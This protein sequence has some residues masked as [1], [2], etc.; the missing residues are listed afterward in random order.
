M[1]GAAGMKHY[2]Q[3]L[4]LIIS[5]ITLFSC[6][7]MPAIRTTAEEP[8]ALSAVDAQGTG[9]GAYLNKYADSASPTQQV[10]I[11]AADYTDTDMQSLTVKQIQDE[12]QNFLY[13]ADEG[14][15]RWHFTVS[16]PGLYSMKVR[17]YTE[18]GKGSAA[19]RTVLIDGRQPYDECNGLVLKRTF[20]Q[21]TQKGAFKKD[22]Q[23]NDIRPAQHEVFGV[24]EQFLY[25]SLGF[26][27]EPLQIYLTAGEHTLDFVSVREP[28][29]LYSI[30]FCKKEDVSYAE[31]IAKTDYKETQD[32]KETVQCEMFYQTSDGTIYPIYD[33]T[34]PIT[35][36]QSASYTLLNTV[37]GG[38][39][40]S[41]GQWISWKITV[42]KDGLYAV[43]PRFR[44][45]TL[46]GMFVT[47][48][49]YIDSEIPFKEAESIQFDYNSSWQY[50]FIS[51]D[52]GK[53]YLF[54]LSAGEH[55]IKMEVV[56]GS[57]APILR[58]VQ[59]TLVSL[60]SC[61]RQILMITGTQ[62]D[63]YRDYNFKNLIPE[64]LSELSVQADRLESVADSIEEKVGGKGLQISLLRKIALQVRRMSAKP[65]TIGQ[66]FESFKTN[67]GSLGSWV[68]TNSCQPLELDYITVASPDKTLEKAD[69]NFFSKLIF[70][71][72]KFVTTFFIDSYS[73][74]TTASTDTGNAKAVKVWLAT[75]RDQASVLRT[76]IDDDFTPASGVPISLELTAAGTLLPAVLAGVGPDV[77]VSSDGPDPVNYALRDAVYDLSK[78]GDFDE[79][80]NR[81]FSSSLEGFTLNDSVYALP[82]TQ[83]FP[84]LFYRK[85]IFG[86]LELT[87]PVTWK[88]FYVVT[89]EIQK[90]NMQVGLASP[91][92]LY[93]ILMYQRGEEL[94]R[95]NGALVNVDSNESLNCFK[96]V[97]DF[98]TQYKLPLTFDFANRFRTGEMPMA[99]MD[100]TLYNQMVVFAPEI[101]GMWAFVPVPGVLRE[102]GTVNN[103]VPVSC[104]G[105]MLLKKAGDKEN[106]WEF[107]KWWTSEDVQA[108]Y[109]KEMENVLGPS[110]K[111]PTA[112]KNA[113]AKLPWI[114]GDYK[115]L[116]SQADNTK[117]VPVYPGS[118]MLE[119]SM[120]FAFT[121]VYNTG[122]NPIESINDYIDEMNDELTRKRKEFDLNR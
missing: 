17:Y 74:G 105:T 68:L 29:S 50:D 77:A 119:R 14:F 71:F 90:Q 27:S 2:K 102:D 3:G 31:Y 91:Y 57:L 82:E 78:F 81:F 110:A 86:Q 101:K 11:N 85:D 115:S 4:S 15:V 62:T 51:D 106:C 9:Y 112:N 24:K 63:V 22:S 96:E 79:V 39:W 83:Q 60:N 93:T 116:S 66:S 34:S 35:Q 7:F 103:T 38:K 44:Q 88:E 94:F 121:K 84:M 87:V 61:Y 76:M 30:T 23:N 100:Y 113:L 41:P 42:P 118:Y 8:A 107:M 16:E 80:K 13:T 20:E 55:E 69:S 47:R 109:G 26:Y 48:R 28:V 117:G 104:L 1:K 37:G 52:K 97:C 99:I 59:E 64:V 6:I 53:P 36:P 12:P 92:S 10:V 25:D 114:T 75:G 18:P 49:L 122:V 120:N 70:D 46:D 32:I 108:R 58:E 65:D 72:R 98:Y 54:A 43:A 111:H 73:I 89:R 56:L 21:E 40:Q 19:E 95:D 45:N 33:V 67:L 5:V